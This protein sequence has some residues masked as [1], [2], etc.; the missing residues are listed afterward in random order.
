MQTHAHT[1]RNYFAGVAQSLNYFCQWAGR[2]NEISCGSFVFS[3]AYLRFFLVIKETCIQFLILT[4][5][6]II[7][8]AISENWILFDQ[9]W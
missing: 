2:S 3:P 4:I 1:K 7:L 6:Y 8:F 9:V 5:A